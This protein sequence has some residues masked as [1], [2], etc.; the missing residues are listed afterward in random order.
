MAAS[1]L[2]PDYAIGASTF[3]V[4]G[5]GALFAAS[6]RAPLTGIVL[7]LE[8]TDNYQLILPMIVTC[9][10]ATL[11]AQFL[12]GSRYILLFWRGRCSD[13][14]WLSRSSRLIQQFL[15]NLE[16]FR[17]LPDNKRM[18]MGLSPDKP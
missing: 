5:M 10:G 1:Q 17:R 4:A 8:M 16:R 12:G 14:R 13:R 3:A 18:N 9:L 6:V 11:L 15:S 2:F 7:V